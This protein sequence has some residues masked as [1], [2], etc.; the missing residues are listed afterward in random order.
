MVIPI[1]APNP[2][3][4]YDW[5]NAVMD[6]EKAAQLSQALGYVPSTQAAIDRLPA[7]IKRDPVKFPPSEVLSRCETMKPLPSDAATIVEQYWTQIKT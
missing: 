4:A 7:E 6:P 2:D 3:M 5:I 1:T